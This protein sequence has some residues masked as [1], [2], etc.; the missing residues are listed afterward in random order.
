MKGNKKGEKT[1]ENP[2]QKKQKEKPPD[3]SREGS[4]KPVKKN[5]TWAG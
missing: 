4:Q 2:C 5:P 1:E 3:S